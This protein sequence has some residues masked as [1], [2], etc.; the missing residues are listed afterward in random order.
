MRHLTLFTAAFLLV[1]G[2][3]S[4]EPTTDALAPT[5]LLGDW[6]LFQRTINQDNIVNM[7]P[8][9]G[10]LQFRADAQL[11]DLTGD[12]TRTVDASTQAG[13]F[14][15]DTAAQALTF[16]YDDKEL[17]VEYA[18]QSTNLKLSYIASGDTINEVWQK[19]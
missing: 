6:Q 12:F 5:Q 18:I 13:T 10:S 3:D 7:L 14:N 1:V 9:Y 8:L 15:V 19:Q 2:C 16:R 17:Y 4:T 11:D